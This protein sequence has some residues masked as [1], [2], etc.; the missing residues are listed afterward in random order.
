MPYTCKLYAGES[1]LFEQATW[2]QYETSDVPREIEIVQK[3]NAKRNV[4]KFFLIGLC[5][6]TKVGQI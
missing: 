4:C 3:A 2:L 6:Y 1:H 5:K